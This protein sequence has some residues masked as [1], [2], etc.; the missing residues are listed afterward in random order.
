VGRGKGGC[1]KNVGC[2]EAGRRGRSR[3]G[4]RFTCGTEERG[5]E[6]GERVPASEG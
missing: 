1:L 5:G 2:G 4:G 3:G 6:E